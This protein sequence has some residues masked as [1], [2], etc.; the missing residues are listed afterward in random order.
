MED[1]YIPF[2]LVNFKDLVGNLLLGIRF[3]RVPVVYE[4]YWTSSR[5][6]LLKNTNF[7]SSGSFIFLPVLYFSGV[8]RP[9]SNT[10]FIISRE[11]SAILLRVSIF[12]KGTLGETPC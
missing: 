9:S 8:P 12:S 6:F 3:T 5:T 2:L 1:Y 10:E 11:G 7:L 4:F